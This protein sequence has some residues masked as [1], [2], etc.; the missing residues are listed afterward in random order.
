MKDDVISIIVP[1]FN[2]EQYIDKCLDTLT[3]QTYRNLEIILI[4]DGSSDNSGKIC[5]AWSGKDERVRVIHQTNSGI[6]VARNRGI[7]CCEG[8]YIGFVDPD[9]YIDLKMYEKLH[10]AIKREKADMAVCHEIA[11]VDGD[12]NVIISNNCSY[13]IEDR[14]ELIDHFNDDFRGALTWVWNKLFTRELIGETRFGDYSA[15]EDTAFMTDISTKVNKCVDIGER[16][17]Y[18]RQRLGSTIKGAKEKIFEDYVKV[19]LYEYEVLKQYGK[20]EFRKLHL[21]K[22]LSLLFQI[23]C[24]A[25][26]LKYYKAECM[27]RTSY[28]QLYEDINVELSLKNKIKFWIFRYL[29]NIGY[30]LIQNK[31]V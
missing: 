2:V 4:D 31:G 10:D 16:L 25:H 19:T 14:H 11:F 24:Q 29:R 23:E 18:Y 1:V 21:S 20:Q 30:L 26:G 7:E 9:D 3:N 12:D 8:A 17:Y 13:V 27:A 28:I 6:S 22:C 5:D 15:M